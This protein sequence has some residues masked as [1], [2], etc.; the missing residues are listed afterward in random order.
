MA[1]SINILEFISILSFSQMHFIFEISSSKEIK[2]MIVRNFN[3]TLMCSI[4]CIF[5]STQ[6][7]KSSCNHF[8]SALLCCSYF[9]HSSALMQS[10]NSSLQ[11]AMLPTPAIVWSDWGDGEC[12]GRQ[13]QLPWWSSSFEL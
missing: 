10:P 3:E 1:K 6:R 4:L 9:L 7:F 8:L 2:K 13:L 5:V 11:L 12:H